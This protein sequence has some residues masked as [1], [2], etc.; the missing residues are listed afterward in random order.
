MRT[1]SLLAVLAILSFAL[2]ACGSDE[3]DYERAQQENTAEAYERFIQRHPDSDFA[4]NAARTLDSLRFET[5]KSAHSIEAY[6]EFVDPFVGGPYK[7]I[8]LLSWNESQKTA[9]FEQTYCSGGGCAQEG[10]ITM[11]FEG[12]TDVP[13]TFNIEIELNDNES[14]RVFLL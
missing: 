13:I 10:V 1:K 4:E 3:E 14:K 6:N 11:W 12:N 9:V 7:G 5:A 2:L 8:Y